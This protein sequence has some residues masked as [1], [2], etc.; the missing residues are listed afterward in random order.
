MPA[1]GVPPALADPAVV[2]L[3]EQGTEVAQAWLVELVATTPLD[4]VH[5]LDTGA[6]ARLGPA[7]CQDVLVSLSSDAA[8]DALPAAATPLI[9]AAGTGGVAGLVTAVE[10]LRRAAW[11]TATATIA[12]ADAGLL[13]ALGDRLAHACSRLTHAALSAGQT[14]TAESAERLWPP[15][16]AGR[17][18]E[19]EPDDDD[20]ADDPGPDGPSLRLAEEPEDARVAEPGVAG[21]PLWREALARRLALGGRYALLMLEIDGADRLEAANQGAAI[22]AAVRQARGRVRRGDLVA[23][24][25]GRLWIVATE[26]GRGAARVLARRLASAVSEAGAL[27]GAPLHA[28]VGLALFPDDGQDADELVEAAEESMFG[29][30]ADG[31]VV[32]DEDSAC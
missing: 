1:Y 32:A 29:A 15:R 11:A 19:P 2:G 31:L 8:L 4:R 20:L 28:S 5:E 18:P 25:P 24:E 30:R 12:H 9:A 3:A 16:P 6:I 21:T 10:S 7:L 26:A 27:H 23:Q 22:E 17:E 13:A 14:V